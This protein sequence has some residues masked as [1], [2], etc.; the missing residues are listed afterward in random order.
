VSL[1][2]AHPVVGCQAVRMLQTKFE[3]LLNNW[4]WRYSTMSN[5]IASQFLWGYR[6]TDHV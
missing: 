4:I 2:L 6:S 1:N 3:Y 5:S